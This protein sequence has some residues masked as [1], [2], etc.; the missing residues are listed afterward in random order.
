LSPKKGL[1][2][3]LKRSGQ[4]CHILPIAIAYDRVPERRSLEAE[5][6]GDPKPPKTLSGLLRWSTRLLRDDI[7]LGHIHLRCGAPV[8]L[9]DQTDVSTCADTILA[10]HR[11]NMAVTRYH[12][13]CFVDHVDPDPFG[14]DDLAEIIEARGG[15]VLDSALAGRPAPTPLAERAYRFQWMHFL[16]PDAHRLWGDH[17]VVR[18]H[19][20]FNH[21]DVDRRGNGTA[22]TDR[23]RAIVAAL[24]GPIADT[25]QHVGRELTRL[26][27]GPVP[28]PEVFFGERHGFKPYVEEA[29]AAFVEEGILNRS[30]DTWSR[31]PQ[32]DQLSRFLKQ[33]SLPDR[34]VTPSPA[35]SLQA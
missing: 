14:V 9:D 34:D 25:Y 26:D 18:H 13:Q 5:L 23:V 33:C 17:P 16:Y 30:G 31:G 24:F 3:A 29:Y 35:S 11:A 20:R 22:P 12:L 28:A 21:Y 32:F 6:R 2:Q 8:T 1:L 7:D 15:R 10:R 4:R 27:G 19:L